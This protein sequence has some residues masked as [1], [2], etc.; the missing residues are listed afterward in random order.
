MAFAG[1]V[2]GACLIAAPAA[3]QAAEENTPASHAIE[4]PETAF[5][6]D[7]LFGTWDKAQLQRGFQ[8]Y[9]N[10]CAACHALHLVSYRNLEALGYNEAE[11]KAIAAAAQITAGPNDEGEMFERP[12]LPSDRFKS[13]F[14]NEQAARFANNGAYPPDLSLMA[15]AREGGPSYIVALLNGYHEPPAGFDLLTGMNYNEYFPGHQIAMPPPLSDGSITTDGNNV[16][17]D[18]TPATVHQMSEDV[19][20]FLMWAAEPHMQTRKQT[21]VKVVLFLLVMTGLLYAAK[22]KVWADLH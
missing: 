21:G 11:I 4:I 19:A 12:G 2:V 5:S 18:G 9:Q 14:P 7:G 6:F 3:P 22:R 16:Y 17:E 10:V 8:V 1:G 20:A 15:K 13:P